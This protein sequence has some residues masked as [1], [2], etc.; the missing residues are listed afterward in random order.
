MYSTDEFSSAVRS[1]MSTQS[2]GSTENFNV[3]LPLLAM[4]S[5]LLMFTP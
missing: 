1:V 3:S 4:V 2:D 5:S